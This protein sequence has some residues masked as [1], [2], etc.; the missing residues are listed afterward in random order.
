MLSSLSAGVPSARLAPRDAAKYS[1]PVLGQPVVYLLAA[2]L[3][4]AVLWLL[5]PQEYVVSDPGA[6][7]KRAYRIAEDGRFG[8]GHIFDQRLAVTLPTALVYRTVGVNILTTNFVV[9][10]SALLIMLTVWL[11]LPDT[12]SRAIGA[13]LCLTSI[14][15]FSSSLVLFPDLI[16]TAFM[17]LS[18][19]LL[20]SRRKV[21]ER[22][23][24]PA[25]VSVAA[26]ALLFIAFLAK[27][28]AYWVLPL[29][30]WAVV[31]DLR[32]SDRAT[33]L[34]R[35]YVPALATAIGLAA[36]YLAFSYATWGDPL[37]R[38]KVIQA[39]TGQHVWSWGEDSAELLARLTVGPPRFFYR[40]YGALILLL[41]AL[42]GS[43]AT[44]PMRPWSF[45]A[46]SCLL[47]FWFGS[48]SFTSYQPLPLKPRQALPILP[49]IYI[50]AACS[51]SRIR[52]PFGSWQR[53]RSLVPVLLILTYAGWR[54][55]A[56]YESRREK[57]FPE[58]VAMSHVRNQIRSDP[59]SDYLLVCSD[60]S[61]VGS[62]SFFF[63]YE[64]PDNLE[65]VYV[66]DLSP[67]QVHGRAAYVYVNHG[68]SS[69]RWDKYGKRHYDA[70]IQSLTFAPVYQE[71]DVLLLRSDREDLLLELIAMS[72]RRRSEDES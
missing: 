30:V 15:L 62:L 5:C 70:E 4:F 50:L 20:F 72:A 69:Y 60:S 27:E 38:F 26:V 53:A 57:V 43:L 37:I 54:F 14:P 17:A 9:L 40:E 59:E 18:A 1:R 67:E 56:H 21:V 45:Y 61:S 22:R 25:L 19:H 12:K 8:A 16:A 3:A 68:R 23:G 24:D 52:I 63:G 29:W 48:S 31:I 34:R 7:S 36:V 58:Q 13:A 42:G 47:L 39:M 46:A 64:Y 6:Y 66:E 71:K 33:L 49:A 41:A 51:A 28:S 35:F 11:A 10:L 2:L 65:V 55:V 32:Q 44:G